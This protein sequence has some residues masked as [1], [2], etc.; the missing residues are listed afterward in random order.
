MGEIQHFAKLKLRLQGK[1][2]LYI[3]TKNRDYLRL[4]QEIEILQQYGKKVD[5]ILSSKKGYFFRI[6]EVV[7][8]TIL[9]KTGS[10]DIVFVGFQPQFI[11]P[12]L[13]W[14][15]RK[16]EI[17]TDFFIS[18]YDTMVY[19]RKVISQT[20]LIAKLAK[21]VDQKTIDA[22]DV[23]ICDTKA[24]G[25][26]FIVEFEAERSKMYVLYLKADT[27]IYYPRPQRKPKKLKDK[28]IVFYFG[29][30]L[31]V[32]GVDVVLD[33]IRMLKDNK[34]IHFIIVGPI[35][36]EKKKIISDT[37]TYINWLPQVKLAQYI[38]SADLCLAGHFS[39]TI[40][41]ANRT[42]P[43]KAY[44][45]RAMNKP[46]VL[47]DSDANRELFTENQEVHFV[48]QGNSIELKELILL[49]SKDVI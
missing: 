24:H 25:E 47:G 41:K 8:R 28:F 37:V 18:L 48:E 3:A 9:N 36:D 22:S 5:C 26:Y 34:D 12:I 29:S 13:K 44:I 23:I 17:W 1:K 4:T 27:S 20:S 11:I 39:A 31:P 45:Y 2:I 15:F 19:D 35:R 16:C 21:Y 14:K 46:I 42:I 32:Q 40:G 6:F 30:I 43:G 7:L 49:M 10:Y 33:T 38:A